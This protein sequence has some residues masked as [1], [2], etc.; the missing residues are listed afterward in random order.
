MQRVLRPQWHELRET[1]NWTPS[2]LKLHVLYNKM[3]IQVTDWE[4]IF[5]IHILNVHD[6]YLK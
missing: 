1:D 4:K 3:K 6:I 5:T 2:K